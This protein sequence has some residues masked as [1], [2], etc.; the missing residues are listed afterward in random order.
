MNLLP[1][2]LTN[3]M[4][5]NRSAPRVYKI[6]AA[7]DEASMYLYDVIGH[8]WWTGGGVTAKQFAGDLMALGGR[9]L[10]LR[11]NSPGGDVF[12]GRAMAAALKAY[13]GKVI[14][15][16]DG[17]AASAASFLIMHAD[18]IVMTAG[19][20][21]MIHNGWTVVM[22]DRHE[23]LES[24]ALLEKIDGAIADDYLTR[25]TAD[26]EQVQAW[27]DAETWFTAEEAISNGL[28]DRIDKTDDAKTNASAWDVSAY[29][30]AP[31]ELVQEQLVLEPINDQEAPVNMQAEAE[32]AHR[33]RTLRLA[34]RTA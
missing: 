11:V 8:D 30:R 33:M 2:R 3:L 27:M 16:V 5:L 17:L 22:G 19:S 20:F 21:M 7:A 13:P 15:H 14:A 1:N 24:A 25:T 9:T 18:E 28:A 23:M 12:D 29:G 31:A 34:T 4:A 10:H 6:D 32:H 26:R